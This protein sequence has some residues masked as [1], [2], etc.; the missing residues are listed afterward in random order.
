MMDFDLTILNGLVVTVDDAEEYDI[1]IK[2]GKI[3]K[4]VPKG[5]LAGF[6]STKSIDAKGGY[7]MVT[8]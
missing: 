2:G 6:S 7:V 4:V 3:A 8:V 5:E 1:G